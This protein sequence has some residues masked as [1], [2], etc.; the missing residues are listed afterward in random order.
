[1]TNRGKERRT[2]RETDLLTSRELT[3]K[4]SRKTDTLTDMTYRETDKQRLT[5]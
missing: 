3:D 4:T 1:M 2:R 5:S